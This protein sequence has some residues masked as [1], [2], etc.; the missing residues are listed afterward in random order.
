MVQNICLCAH[1]M[2]FLV[3]QTPVFY[4]AIGI[5]CSIHTSPKCNIYFCNNPKFSFP[6]LFLINIVI[7]PLTLYILSL[8]IM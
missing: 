2:I 4:H 7:H 8:I 3:F 5:A 1:I 6:R